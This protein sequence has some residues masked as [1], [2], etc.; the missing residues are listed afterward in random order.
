MLQNGSG[1]DVTHYHLKLE[2][3]DTSAFIS[4]ETIITS[5]LTSS[6][7]DSLVIDFS[8]GMD[9]HEVFLNNASV[10]YTHQNDQLILDVQDD[11][12][13]PGEIVKV[14][15]F[16]SGTPTGT[17]QGRAGVYNEVHPYEEIP[18]TYSLSEPFSAKNWFPCK[19][20]LTD[21]ADSVT[22]EFTVEKR[23]KVGSN[24]LLVNTTDVGDRHVRYTWKSKYPIAYYL[25]SFSV[26]EYSEYNLYAHPKGHTDS[27]L[28]INYIPNT[29]GYL[30]KQ[31]EKIDVTADLINYFSDIFTL[32]PFA[33]EKYGHAVAPF[34]GGMEHQ[35]M[36]TMFYFELFLVAHELAHQWFGDNVTCATWQDIWVNEGFA[37]YSEY[38]TYQR[39]IDQQAADSWMATAHERAL[40]EPYGSVYVPFEES[41][42]ESRIFNYNLSYKKGAALLHMLRYEIDNDSVFFSTFKEFQTAFKDSVAT[43]DDFN[44]VVN[45]ITGN[46]YDYFFDQWYY[47]KGFPVFE[48][49]WVQEDDTLY[50][51]SKQ[52]G[53]DNPSD[54]FKT[55]VEF[56]VN[57]SLSSD[58]V[59]Y[60]QHTSNAIFKAYAPQQ[61]TGLQFDPENWLLKSLSS[62]SNLD[63]EMITDTYFDVYP[64]P[65]STEITVRINQPQLLNSRMRIIS[66]D[67]KVVVDKA[68]S[69]HLNE[70]DV[71]ALNDGVY[72]IVVENEGEKHIQR[73]VKTSS[74]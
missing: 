29:A 64:N 18:V 24:G 23:L 72:L 38:L 47:G 4:G 55:S 11:I 7:N 10:Q 9:I 40:R 73:F 44:N 17:Y 58:T 20:D 56:V 59:K 25:I 35:T 5:V 42:N 33:E 27:I 22:L 37:S 54:L 49:N 13:S 6:F 8:T 52:T 70:F 31:R 26:A 67:G 41:T 30:E 50:I 48:I 21:K 57:Y 14:S 34:G 32:Y 19:Q 61:V 2:L 16:Y 28:I 45:E 15:V 51:Y 63:T 12:L 36:S 43:G 46:D 53:S 3:S 66:I 69:S 39:F 60:F 74:E 71:R 65:G 68:I 62:R 1:Y